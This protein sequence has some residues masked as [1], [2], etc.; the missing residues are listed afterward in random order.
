MLIKKEILQLHVTM[1]NVAVM[2]VFDALTH[3]DKHNGCG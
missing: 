3:L 2:E 1:D